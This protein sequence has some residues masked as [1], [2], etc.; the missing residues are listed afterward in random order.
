MSLSPEMRTLARDIIASYDRRI[1]SIRALAE[2]TANLLS[3]FRKEHDRV[4]N[5]LRR[6][7]EIEVKALVEETSGLLAGFREDIDEIAEALRKEPDAEEAHRLKEFQQLLRSIQA[8][9]R[10]SEKDVNSLLALLRAE[11]QE[12]ARAWQQMSARMYKSEALTTASALEAQNPQEGSVRR[13]KTKKCPK[14][15]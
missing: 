7:L 11:R 2:E 13:K 4:V 9:Q 10:E 3:S 1:R 12:I 8:R 5:M 15:G 14:G 6:S